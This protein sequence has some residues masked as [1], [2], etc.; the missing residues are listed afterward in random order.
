MAMIKVAG[1]TVYKAIARGPI[2][3]M[4]KQEV[5]ITDATVADVE[6]EVAR[7]TEAF[8][9]AIAQIGKLYEKALA[10]V[11]EESAAIFEVHQMMLEDDEYLD[12]I[13][14]MIRDE[15]M[16]AVFAVKMTGDTFSQIFASMDDEYMKARATDILDI[17]GRVIRVLT[18]Q[19]DVSLDTPSIILA[20]DLTPSETVQMDKSKILGFVTVH[21]STN[22]HTA[23]LARMMNIPALVMTPV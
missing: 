1:K 12:S 6:A 18:G 11:G 2:L 19:A 22:S 20:D 5:D 8:E 15:S 7:V 14:N 13:F 17:S 23:I 16:N 3:V 4:N 10:E 21:G 9:T